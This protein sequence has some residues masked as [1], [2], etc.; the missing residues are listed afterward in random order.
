[1]YFKPSRKNKDFVFLPD[2]ILPVL[3]KILHLNGYFRLL[4]AG[5]IWPYLDKKYNDYFLN[6]LI[7]VVI[8]KFQNVFCYQMIVFGDLG[9]VIYSK[10]SK[11][12]PYTVAHTIDYVCSKMLIMV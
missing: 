7:Q 3:V 5:D 10:Y 2:P 4:V 12:W 11:H 9:K 6:Y 8:I 1:M